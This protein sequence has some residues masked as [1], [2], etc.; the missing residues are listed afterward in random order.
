MVEEYTMNKNE[1]IT[2]LRN[3]DEE[4]CGKYRAKVKGVFGS[5]IRGEDRQGSDLDVLVEFVDGAT[6]LDF[7]GLALYLEDKLGIAVDIVPADTIKSELKD[8]ILSETV[9]V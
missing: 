6:L 4:I 3:L 1:I 9:F 7:V 8:R 5:V 2:E